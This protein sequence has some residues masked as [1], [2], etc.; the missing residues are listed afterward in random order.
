MREID[1]Y[2]GK[3][4]RGREARLMKEWESID[5]LFGRM[6]EIF[7]VVRK[8]NHSGLPIV[9]EVIYNIH[10]FCGVEE[11][12]ASGLRKPVFA[13]RFIMRI[14]IP[15]NYPSV[16]AKLEF[17]FR[18]KDFDGNPIPHPWHPN[19]RYFGDF[20]GRVC[21]NADACGSYTDLSWYIDRVGQYLRYGTYHA[22][23]GV[24]PFPEDD[25]VA[26]WVTEQGEPQGWIRQL[27]EYH[28]LN[29]D[30]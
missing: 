19:I 15:N 28:N 16:E 20:A 3:K 26:E 10:S 11:P 27:Q 14:T 1:N 29:I 7:C 8:R 2:K 21:L 5:E 30:N 25:K 18:I 23:I 22:Q 6:G 13:D 9:Y 4:F 17:K 24:P 12:D